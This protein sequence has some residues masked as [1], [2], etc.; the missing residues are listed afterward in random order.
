M[1]LGFPKPDKWVERAACDPVSADDWYG[2]S[3]D[4]RRGPKTGHASDHAKALCARCDVRNECL[5]TAI[6][7][8]ERWGIWAGIDFQHDRDELARRIA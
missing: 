6:A 2:G 4:R 1:S 5:A 7:N 8:D 3:D